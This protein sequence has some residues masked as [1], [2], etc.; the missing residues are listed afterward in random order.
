MRLDRAL[1][2]ADMVALTTAFALSWLLFDAPLVFESAH[3]G[4]AGLAVAAPIAWVLAARV[5]GLYGARSLREEVMGVASLMTMGVWIVTL[6]S[7]LSGRPDP[8]IGQLTAFW[9]GAI[10]AIP[11]ARRLTGATFPQHP[12]PA[13][14]GLD[15][16]LAAADALAVVAAAMLS[17][18]LF[19]EPRPADS[20]VWGGAF[21]LASVVLW[22]GLAA[23]TGGYASSD[24]PARASLVRDLRAVVQLATVPAWLVIVLTGPGGEIDPDIPQVAM[25]WALTIVL[26]VAARQLARRHRPAEPGRP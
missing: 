7:S 23:G 20:A 6:A 26:A 21:V 19:L 11:A 9:L 15:R 18:P 12:A 3:V 25:W 1:V 22:M 10:V 16:R 17:S 13:R 5:A 14:A 4:A 2:V 8:D 24:A